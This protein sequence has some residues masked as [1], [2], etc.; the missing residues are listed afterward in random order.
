MNARKKLLVK[1]DMERR[2][3]KQWGGVKN[4]TVVLKPKRKPVERPEEVARE[5]TSYKKGT[6]DITFSFFFKVFW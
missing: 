6:A 2:Q 5:I 3:S 1:R 4:K